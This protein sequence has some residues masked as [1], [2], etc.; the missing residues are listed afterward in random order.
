MS[1]IMTIFVM[2]IAISLFIGSV[3]VL[4]TNCTR[5]LFC[6]GKLIVVISSSC[7]LHKK[8]QVTLV[9]I[10]RLSSYLFLPISPTSP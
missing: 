6:P 7:I 8:I 2:I 1:L 3:V 9:I 4:N 10:N 5:S